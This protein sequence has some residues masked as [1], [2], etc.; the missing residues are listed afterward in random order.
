MCCILENLRNNFFFLEKKSNFK[1]KFGK[2][3]SANLLK[4]SSMSLEEK[5]RNTALFVFIKSSSFHFSIRVRFCLYKMVKAK[6]NEKIACQIC[7]KEYSSKRTFRNHQKS[8]A[9]E[10]RLKRKAKKQQKT[11]CSKCGKEFCNQR[12][13]KRHQNSG[14]CERN[15]KRKSKKLTHSRYGRFD[16]LKCLS[17]IDCSYVFLS[18]VVAYPRHRCKAYGNRN[19]SQSM[20]KKSARCKKDHTGPCI[21][22]KVESDMIDFEKESHEDCLQIEEEKDAQDQKISRAEVLEVLF[23]LEKL[24]AKA[25]KKGLSSIRFGSNNS[26]THFLLDYVEQ[27]TGEQKS[28]KCW[29]DIGRI[30]LAVS[31]KWCIDV[32]VCSN[33]VASLMLHVEH[34]K[35]DIK[36]V[37]RKSR[38]TITTSV[39]LHKQFQKKSMVL[40]ISRHLDKR[41][42]RNLKLNSLS[43]NYHKL[44][45]TNTEI[46][47]A[48]SLK[49][50]NFRGKQIFSKSIERVFLTPN[51]IK[52]EKR[53]IEGSIGPKKKQ[54]RIHRR[55]PTKTNIKQI[56]ETTKRTILEADYKVSFKQVLTQVRKD[57]PGTST[58]L[59]FF[60]TLSFLTSGGS[61]IS[62][63]YRPPRSNVT[64]SKDALEDLG[65]FYFK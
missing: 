23:R 20:T 1:I 42:P 10:R 2:I 25:K 4:L 36:V 34:S 46:N 13:S 43:F 38:K 9:C 21:A 19:I 64:D 48:N 15:L 11:V 5:K 61:K 32:D 65:D 24:V 54:K 47:F 14:A 17:C 6:A 58:A 44:E 62:Q 27:I 56:N 50:P 45:K 40:E 51:Q 7:L 12:T 41:F 35:K 16:K 57:S 26:D 53:S 3:C 31:E 37:K 33:M 55:N 63:V 22:E 30:I 39:A 60:A 18:K 28:K 8:R 59:G 52:S 49:I 29:R